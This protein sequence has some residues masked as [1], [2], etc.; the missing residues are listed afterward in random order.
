MTITRKESR[1]L[2]ETR[3]SRTSKKNLVFEVDECS[4]KIVGEYAQRFITKGGCVMRKFA[5]LDGTTWK[6]QPDS[7]KKDIIT[8]SVVSVIFKMLTNKSDIYI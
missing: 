2:G 3:K 4:G 1:A 8:K 6:K 7:L 5:K